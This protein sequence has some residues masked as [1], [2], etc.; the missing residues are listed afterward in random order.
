[1]YLLNRF[2]YLFNSLNNTLKKYRKSQG[3][4]SARESGNHVSNTAYFESFVELQLKVVKESQVHK[5]EP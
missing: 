2:L 3:N 4:L 5:I 1:M